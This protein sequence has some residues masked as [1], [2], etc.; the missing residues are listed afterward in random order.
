MKQLNYYGVKELSL[1]E[2][3]SIY[4]GA[5]WVGLGMKALELVKK[6]GPRVLEYGY[7]AYEIATEFFTSRS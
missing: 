3:Q 7:M 2:C 4:G 1:Q 5:N 6:Y